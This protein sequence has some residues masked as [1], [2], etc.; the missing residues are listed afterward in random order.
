M[1][2]NKNIV[3]I[4]TETELHT[5]NRAEFLETMLEDFITDT[6]ALYNFCKCYG[7]EY[8]NGKDAFNFLSTIINDMR[9]IY[10]K[11][12]RYSIFRDEKYYSCFVETSNQEKFIQACLTVNNIDYFKI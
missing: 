4:T 8:E 1:D 6:D 12:P 11:N 9:D 2:F 5:Y 10:F 7:I 3:I